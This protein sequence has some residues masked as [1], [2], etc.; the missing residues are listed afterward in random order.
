MRKLTFR[1]IVFGSILASMSGCQSGS[2]PG[3]ASAGSTISTTVQASDLLLPDAT[4]VDRGEC[5]I[6]KHWYLHEGLRLIVWVVRPT[7]DGPF[8]AVVWNHG[9]RWNPAGDYSDPT[10]RL[11]T[12]CRNF[13]EVVDGHEWLIVL[14]EGR[15]YGG[16][17]GQQ[18][19]DFGV[20]DA[21]G[22]TFGY[23]EARARDAN[24]AVD[25]LLSWRDDIDPERIVVAGPS[26]GGMTTLFAAGTYDYAG[27]VIMAAG[28]WCSYESGRP[29]NADRE[30]RRASRRIESPLL[31]MHAVNDECVPIRNGRLIAD[32]AEQVNSDVTFVELPSAVGISGHNQFGDRR[33]T[34][35]G[36]AFE[37][38]MD[39]VLGESATVR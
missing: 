14:P 12:P 31:V 36:Q 18:L 27:A 15:G 9:S 23:L 17:D 24:A 26:H 10:I 19:S 35:W 21:S 20:G 8:P 32:A 22:R 2:S 7:G 25:W 13:P 29:S 4:I 34:L 16:S 11:S 5:I 39:R 3:L 30:I 28:G 37:A 6:E 33:R 1:S 38:F